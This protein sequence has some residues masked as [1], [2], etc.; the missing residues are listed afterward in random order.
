MA[1]VWEGGVV[2]A[3]GAGFP[4]HLKLKARVEIVVANGAEC[5]PLLQV[6]RQL[7]AAE[8]GVILQA[9]KAV[10]EAVGAVRAYVAL[11]A[12]YL[13]AAETI[14]R[15]LPSYPGLELKFVPDVYPVGD[16]QVLVFETTGRLVPEGGIPPQVGVLVL[17]IE[18]LFNIYN[19]LTGWPV[20]DKYVTVTGA[21]ARPLTLKVPIG[22]PVAELLALVNP[23]A[24]D[25]I[26]LDGGP[27]M[28]KPI[29]PTQAVVTK[30]TK[31]LIVLPSQHPLARRKQLSARV[32]LK[33]A[34]AAC[35]Q[36]RECTEFCPRYLLGQAIEPHKTLRSVTYGVSSDS[37]SILSA[38]LCSECGLCDLFACTLELSPRQVNIA[39][40]AELKRQGY[41]PQPKNR[42]LKVRP[43][44]KHRQVPASRLLARLGL[45]P[46]ERPAPLSLELYQPRQVILPLQQ[47]A[48]RPVQPL[49]RPGDKVA[50]GEVIGR[51]AENEMGANL[52]A[53]IAGTVVHV[54]DTIVIRA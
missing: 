23:T 44:R 34:L 3:G 46:Y 24:Q 49:V 38:F 45:L 26:V 54:G 4:T 42:F 6:D 17:N 18:T 50:R 7:L 11:K 12:K 22:T 40:K 53:S 41:R 20:V 35:C 31:G 5:E 37:S 47:G 43:W 1:K 14:K 30:T 25:F 48:G 13:E 33:R 15:L 51:L 16:E 28:G 39:L 29:L 9:L 2:G 21:V 52:H 19:A 36:C 32:A 27:M 8:A 10:K